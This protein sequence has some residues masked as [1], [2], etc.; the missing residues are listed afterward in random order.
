VS[1]FEIISLYHA[2]TTDILELVMSPAEPIWR[3]FSDRQSLVEAAVAL[4]RQAEAASGDTFS[5]VLAGGQT[6][7]ALYRRLASEPMNWEKWRVYFGDERC[8]PPDHPDRNSLQARLA[9]LDHVPI[10]PEHIFTPPMEL[11]P[12][13][14]ASRYGAMLSDAGEFD[15]VLLGLGEDGHTASLFP[16][17]E[18]GLS[19]DAP[20]VLPVFDAPKPPPERI[21]LSAR[22]LSRAQKVIFLVTGESK[23]HAVKRWRRGEPIPAAKISARQS[24]VVL[25][26]S[27]ACP[28]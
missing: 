12:A 7:L 26:D 4:I 10:T 3:V 19:Q 5:I 20:D 11:G 2:I 25:A 14:A 8:L 24:L 6:P 17:H 22:R 16:G 27:A 15:L 23:R 21:T 9:L 28:D 13:G 1:F 18:L